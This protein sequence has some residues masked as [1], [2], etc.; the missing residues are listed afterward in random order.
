MSMRHKS[1]RHI[2]FTEK[3]SDC[4]GLNGPSRWLCGFRLT[5]EHWLQVTDEGDA[6][7]DL[8]RIQFIDFALVDVSE[9]N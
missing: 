9:V 6:T 8:H 3:I 5:A 7:T 1:G 2:R 4:S